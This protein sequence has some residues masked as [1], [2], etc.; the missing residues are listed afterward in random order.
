MRGSLVKSGQ[1]FAQRG[2][3]LGR[4]AERG[5]DRVTFDAADAAMLMGWCSRCR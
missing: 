5:A 1:D 3:E 4:V 2:V